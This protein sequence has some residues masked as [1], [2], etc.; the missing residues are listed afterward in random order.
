MLVNLC[1]MDNKRNVRRYFIALIAAVAV[2]TS[3]SMTGVILFGRTRSPRTVPNPNG[4]D[5][6]LRA[7]Q[8][9]TGNIDDAPDLDHERLRALVS[10]N[11]ESLRLLRMGLA[12]RCAVPTDAQIANFGAVATSDLIGLKKL[13]KVLS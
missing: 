8:A 7:G 10:A 2:L 5:S 1:G 9:V 13:A 11:A 4:Y 3:A 6:L 12:Q